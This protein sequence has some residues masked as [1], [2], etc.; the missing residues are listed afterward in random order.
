MNQTN[1]GLRARGV[2][3]DFYIFCLVEQ[4][5]DYLRQQAYG[6]IFDTITTRTFQNTRVVRP[7]AKLA[8]VFEET[9]EPM[10]GRVLNNQQQSQT[11]ATLR[12]TLLPRL[13]SGALRV[14]LAEEVLK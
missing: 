6:T 8:Q 12:D 7:P 1:Y 11:L 2:V 10:F 3:G 4:V 5:V 13:L 14:P 9:V